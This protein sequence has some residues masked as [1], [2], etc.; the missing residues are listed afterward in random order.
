MCIRDSCHAVLDRHFSPTVPL[1]TLLVSVPDADPAAALP[2]PCGE[3]QLRTL[4]K[5]PDWIIGTPV[6]ISVQGGVVKSQL[7]GTDAE[8]PDKVQALIE[9]R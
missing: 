1:P 7:G 8:D 2:N 6:L 9:F 4:P 5:G 3:C